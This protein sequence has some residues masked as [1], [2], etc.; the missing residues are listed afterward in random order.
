MPN[1]ELVMLE[2]SSAPV[3]RASSTKLGP[4][5]ALIAVA[6]LLIVVAFNEADMPDSFV[7]WFINS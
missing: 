2:E 7:R 4:H 6:A 5:S 3:C 1:A